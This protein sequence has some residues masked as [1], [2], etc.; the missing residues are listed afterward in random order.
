MTDVS[1]NNDL[2]IQGGIISTNSHNL[3]VNRDIEITGGRLNVS[4][5]SDNIYVGRNWSNTAG[6]TAFNENTGTVTL[7]SSQAATVSTETFSNLTINKTSVEVNDLVL[8]TRQTLT[9]NGVLS[10]YSG[11]LKVEPNSTLDANGNVSVGSGGGLDLNSSGTQTT[12]KLAGNLWDD[13]D[14]VNTGLGLNAYVGSSLIFDGIGNQEL[15]SDYISPLFNLCN[16][17]INKSGGKVLSYNHVNFLGNFQITAGEWSY[18]T[19]GRTKNFYGDIIINAAGVYSDSTGTNNLVNAMDS[20]LKILGS[21]KFGTFVINKTTTNN[22]TLT[23][24]VTLSGNTTI[25]LTAGILNLQAYQFKYTGLLTVGADGKVNLTAGSVLNINN[26]STFALGQYGEL[27]CAGSQ[28]NPAK[29]TSDTGYYTFSATRYSGISAAYTIFEKMNVNGINFD[30]RAVIDTLNCFKYC[31]F[32]NSEPG[33]TLLKIPSGVY[34]T[35]TGA[36]FPDN[37]PISLY[38]VSRSSQPLGSVRFKN[39]TG[40]F[41]GP[42]YQNPSHI[43]IIWENFAPYAPRNVML[44]IVNNQVYLTWDAVTGVSGYKIY[45]ADSYDDIENA[46]EIGSTWLTYYT[47]IVYLPQSCPLGFYYVVS[48]N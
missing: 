42:A 32:R 35:I 3:T 25:T 43:N 28:A 33:G 1:I 11:C 48:Y 10:I 31:S 20:N 16:V 18:A 22:V 36:D 5:D 12:F 38:N 19:A 13:N 2:T 15:G 26:N 41:S 44:Q 17:V 45:R 21:A 46:V 47:D 8:N 40:A 6:T 39:Y 4:Q 9:V 27:V 37:P 24:N 14:E 29:L 23:G 34:L 30:F 7:N